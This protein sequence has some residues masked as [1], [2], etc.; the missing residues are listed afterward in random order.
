VAS[1]C[2]CNVFRRN[3]S[4][5][6]IAEKAVLLFSVT[7]VESAA[8]ITYRISDPPLPGS[9]KFGDWERLDRFSRDHEVCA[10]Y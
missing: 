9:G 10:E 3:Q 4:A 1:V 6:E 8:E 7:V 2:K 5:R